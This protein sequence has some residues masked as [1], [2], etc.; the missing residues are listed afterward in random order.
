MH[1]RASDEYKNVPAKRLKR[2]MK[3]P[4]ENYCAPGVNK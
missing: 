4:G 3:M 1:N 2:L